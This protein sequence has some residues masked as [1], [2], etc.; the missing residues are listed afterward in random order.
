[1]AAYDH[2][3]VA[4]FI[5]PSPSFPTI[6]NPFIAFSG[7]NSLDKAP[8]GRVHDFVKANGGHTVI[9]K[10]SHEHTDNVWSYLPRIG[11]HRQ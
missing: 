10:V 5:G 11:S 2:A 9:T 4:H 8:V 3:K 7:G 6:S 1:M